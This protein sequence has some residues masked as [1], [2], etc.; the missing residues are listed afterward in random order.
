MRVA[1]LGAGTGRSG[2]ALLAAY[3][4]MRLTLI[5]PDEVGWVGLQ[6]GRVRTSN[7]DALLLPCTQILDHCQDDRASCDE[8][9]DCIVALQAVRHIVAPPAHYA[10]KL[11]LTVVTGHVFLGDHVVHQHPGVYAHCRLLETAGFT[12]IDVAWRQNDWFVIGARRPAVQS[13]S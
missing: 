13:H 9:Y 12:D 11:N 4:S 3:P 10:A 6:V 1:D 8:G 5:E 7:A 2:Q